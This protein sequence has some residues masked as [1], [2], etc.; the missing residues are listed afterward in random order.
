MAS[1]AAGGT[2]MLSA[3]TYAIAHPLFVPPGVNIEGLGC[4]SSYGEETNPFVTTILWKGSQGSGPMMDFDH[5]NARYN[6]NVSGIMVNG[7]AVA[8]E[9]WRLHA[10]TG[11]LFQNCILSNPEANGYGITIGTASSSGT[12]YQF[13]FG[14]CTF[15]NVHVVDMLPGCAALTT[16]GTATPPV[17]SGMSGN[18]FERCTFN[19]GVNSNAL[20][21]SALSDTNMFYG[22]D[23]NGSGIDGYSLSVH[24]CG[25][26][27]NFFGGTLSKGDGLGTA[28][29]CA[30][31]AN[32]SFLYCVYIANQEAVMHDDGNGQVVLRDCLVPT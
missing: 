25:F 16:F 3:G 29:Y 23:V 26:N 2:L 9:I 4:G 13:P 1:L 28:I 18:V 32:Q 30:N 20:E 6:G 22:C 12:V 31:N 7:A 19:G 10:A 17:S 21:I 8:S 15:R 11:C 24:D 14:R 27:N 5:V